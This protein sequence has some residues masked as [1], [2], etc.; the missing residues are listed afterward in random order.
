MFEW[1][2]EELVECTSRLGEWRSGGGGGGGGP[3]QTKNGHLSFRLIVLREVSFEL[4]FVF[5]MQAFGFVDGFHQNSTK[6]V[7]SLAYLLQWTVTMLANGGDGGGSKGTTDL[8][9][10]S[11]SLLMCV[12]Y[13]VYVSISQRQWN[14]KRREHWKCI[15]Q[16]DC[17][18]HDKSICLLILHSLSLSLVTYVLCS[19]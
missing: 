5:Q 16:S 17:I 18:M 1:A 13:Y 4:V 15:V 7:E 3:R 10:E 14:W 19:H 2:K 6:F 8:Q 12:M 11:R 9:K